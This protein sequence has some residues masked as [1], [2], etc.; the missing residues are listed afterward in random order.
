LLGECCEFSRLLQEKELTKASKANE[1]LKSEVKS[2]KRKSLDKAKEVKKL[3]QTVQNVQEE[4]RQAEVDK[5]VE[6]AR[7]TKF[8]NEIT[9]DVAVSESILHD[10]EETLA[11][12]VRA[13]ADAAREQGRAEGIVLERTRSLSRLNDVKR[14]LKDLKVQNNQLQGDKL[15][16]EA[17]VFGIA[18]EIKKYEVSQMK[19]EVEKL[20]SHIQERESE[21]LHLSQEIEKLHEDL[22]L[23]GMRAVNEA[24]QTLSKI[25]HYLLPPSLVCSFEKIQNLDTI[26]QSKRSVAEMGKD[27]HH[28]YTSL[29]LNLLNRILRKL[30]AGEQDYPGTFKAIMKIRGVGETPF[31]MAIK[32]VIE[33]T[34]QAPMYEVMFTAYKNLRFIGEKVNSNGGP[35][36][37]LAFPL[38]LFSID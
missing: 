8:I 20:Q 10:R 24:E 37:S 28:L 31:G 25:V 26:G 34:T 6:A 7:A 13:E 30:K 36:C 18:E 9:Q 12:T 2:A 29:A 33:E 11:E 14:E 38:L 17:N 1:E 32:G 15:R 35:L 4:Q 3:K 23:D 16:M 22:L 21:I 5:N 19:S 27:L